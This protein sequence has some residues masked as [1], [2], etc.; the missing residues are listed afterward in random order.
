MCHS[1]IR[2]CAALLWFVR[3]APGYGIASFFAKCAA[4]RRTC[5]IFTAKCASILVLRCFT[6][7]CTAARP[8]KCGTFGGRKVAHMLPCFQGRRGVGCILF[9]ANRTSNQGNTTNVN[10]SFS[11]ENEK[12]AAQVGF[13]PTTYCLRGRCSTN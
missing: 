8:S 6:R 13:E 12:R 9:D 4:I 1:L 3:E 2:N 10:I 11:M 7:Q 5:C